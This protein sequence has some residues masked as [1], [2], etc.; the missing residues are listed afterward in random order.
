M[1]NTG[2][3]LRSSGLALP[4]GYP[5]SAGPKTS[6]VLHRATDIRNQAAQWQAASKRGRCCHPSDLTSMHNIH[7]VPETAHDQA[8][9]ITTTSGSKYLEVATELR[10][11]LHEAHN[12]THSGQANRLENGQLD[13]VQTPYV[14]LVSPISTCPQGANNDEPTGSQQR[15]KPCTFQVNKQQQQ[16][17]PT[18]DLAVFTQ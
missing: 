5:D 9:Q 14:T 3:G 15:L 10:V 7:A 6:D 11:A 16:N 18:R 13:Q 12:D 1:D 2:K 4:S 8:R 17:W